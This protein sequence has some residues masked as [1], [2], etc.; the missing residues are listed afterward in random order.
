MNTALQ[1]I[2]ETKKLMVYSSK[3][4]YTAAVT[5]GFGGKCNSLMLLTNAIY[6]CITASPCSGT[7]EKGRKGSA[8]AGGA[9]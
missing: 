1:D 6:C 2:S 9:N 5:A 7:R 3:Y 8:H 4:V